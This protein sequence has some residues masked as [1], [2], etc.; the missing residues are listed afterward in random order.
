[1]RPDPR[2]VAMSEAQLQDLLSGQIAAGLAEVA[3]VQGQLW[4]TG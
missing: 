3:A 2:A 1:M 4:E